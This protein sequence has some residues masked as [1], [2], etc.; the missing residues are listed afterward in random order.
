M[1]FWQIL[2]FSAISIALIYFA[3]F[4]QSSSSVQKGG[5]LSGSEEQPFDYYHEYDG[6]AI[7]INKGESKIYL[8][9][10][11][12]EKTY[13][14]KEVRKWESSIQSNEVYR[15]SGMAGVAASL[16]VAANN[17]KNTGLFIDTRDID[18]PK[19]T[20]RFKIDRKI[21]QS[22]GRWIEILRQSI[23]ES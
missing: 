4:K 10:G 11:K 17:K 19:W 3:F 1:D 7:G 5:K 15:G 12:V 13:S 21:E 8:K 23:N 22:L 2:I 20:I 14:F 16:S 18:N 6:T 9:N